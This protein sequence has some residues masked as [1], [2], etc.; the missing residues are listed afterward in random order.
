MRSPV[1]TS[2][3]NKKRGGGI[4]FRHHNSI[5]KH[6]LFTFTFETRFG[7]CDVAVFGLTSMNT[8]FFV[9]LRPNTG[10]GLP[11]LEVSRSH[12]TTLHIP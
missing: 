7:F 9:A 2:V 11:I 5:N 10:Y 3:Q 4:L 12:I 6:S 8:F 1:V